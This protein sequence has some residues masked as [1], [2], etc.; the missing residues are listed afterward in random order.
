MFLMRRATLCLAVLALGCGSIDINA[1]DESVV[2]PGMT[3]AVQISPHLFVDA[4]D[5]NP[6]W[7]GRS[8]VDRPLTIHLP[9]GT[10]TVTLHFRSDG[11]THQK[12]TYEFTTTESDPVDLEIH[13]RPGH[14]Y[15][16]GYRDSGNG[17][18]P[19]FREVDPAG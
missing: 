15:S 11:A 12:I 14:A 5:G 7:S 10:H 17:W 8:T 3:A 18:R 4:V 9:S 6:E 13:V 16:I 1:F 2:G 19:V